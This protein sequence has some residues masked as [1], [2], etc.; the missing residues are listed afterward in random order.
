[1]SELLVLLNAT[2][3]VVILVTTKLVMLK[4]LELM[5]AT[6]L[7]MLMCMV[8]LVMA[9]LVMCCEES[10][11]MRPRC[12]NLKPQGRTTLSFCGTRIRFWKAVP[13]RL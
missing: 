8:L 7:V 2:K 3:L 10:I 1:M 4:L 11:E 6:K 12:Y 5:T 9:K 13:V